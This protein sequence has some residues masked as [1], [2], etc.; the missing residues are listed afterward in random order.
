MDYDLFFVVYGVRSCLVVI[1][2]NLCMLHIFV[3]SGV[4]LMPFITNNKFVYIS[5]DGN[6]A[7]VSHVFK[8]LISHFL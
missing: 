4:T 3:S 7:L 6:L 8:S 1:I 2:P 5:F